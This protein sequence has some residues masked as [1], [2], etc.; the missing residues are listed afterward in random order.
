MTVAAL[1]IV[2]SP[3]RTST[4]PTAISCC[5]SASE[6]VLSSSAGFC[7]PVVRLS[8]AALNLPCLEP[9]QAEPVKAVRPQH[10]DV[11]LTTDSGKNAAAEHL[12]R[13][14]TRKCGEVQLYRLSGFRQVVHCKNCLTSE[15]PGEREHA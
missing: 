2:G 12:D 8:A 9:P 15:R 4:W 13:N 7:G 6:S 5:S 3:T 11:E 14:G 1:F 10:H